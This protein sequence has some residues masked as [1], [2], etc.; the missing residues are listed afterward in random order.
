MAVTYGGNNGLLNPAQNNVPAAFNYFDPMGGSGSNYAGNIPNNPNPGAP[1]AYADNLQSTFNVQPNTGGVGI[2][3]HFYNA[4]SSDPD[5]MAATNIQNE[6][7][8]ARL[9]LN[10]G[11]SFNAD[12]ALL[13]MYEGR[14]G[15]K[16]ALGQII[17]GN[18]QNELNAIVNDQ[19]QA[20]SAVGQGVNNTRRNFASHGL[21]YSG[22]RQAGEQSVRGNVAGALGQS[23]AGT[24]QD[25]A[26]TLSSAEGAY[27][28]VDLASQTQTLGMAQN[29]V[30][31]ASANNI[32]RLQAMQQLGAGVGSAAG[33][34]A[35]SNSANGNPASYVNPAA[36]WD[37]SGSGMNTPYDSGSGQFGGY[38]SN[39]SYSNALGD[40]SYSANGGG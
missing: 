14:I 20:N 39:P 34:V 23:L 26:N 35:G 38:L 10:H 31:S 9:G 37:P 28:Q 18:G 32:A 5:V 17:A 12:D 33:Q 6:E 24:K 29:A 2:G 1:S 13:N 27:G 15:Q 7:V 11:V 4:S 19:N 36:G 40:F 8:D 21:L 25:Y 22:M 30:N 3:G 16:N